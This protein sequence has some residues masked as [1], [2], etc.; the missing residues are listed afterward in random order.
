MKTKLIVFAFIILLI[1]ALC[2]GFYFLGKSRAEIKIIKE[3]VEVVKYVDKQKAEIYS[4]P[5][6]SA[7]AIFKLMRKGLF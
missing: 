4:K 1:V 7:D 3:Q 2:T 5:P 6:A